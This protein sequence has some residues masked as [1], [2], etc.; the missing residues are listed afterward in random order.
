EKYEPPISGERADI[1]FNNS[2]SALMQAFIFRDYRECRHRAGTSA[3]PPRG[4][5]TT[6]IPASGTIAILVSASNR[7][8]AGCVYACDF[9][10]QP[11]RRYNF[12][13]LET[14]D[15]QEC[16]YMVTEET[17]NGATS[18]PLRSRKLTTA[19]DEN[20]PFCETLP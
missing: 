4:Q 20:S 2:S 17:A 11:S 15:P 16:K 3:V 13:Y 14:D 12:R 19:I 18:I 6:T 8:T 7:I 1:T 10:P 9:R 5:L